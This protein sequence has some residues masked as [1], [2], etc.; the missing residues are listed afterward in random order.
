MTLLILKILLTLLSL[1]ALI[2]LFVFFFIPYSTRRRMLD[3]SYGTNTTATAKSDLLLLAI[4]LIL[5]GLLF[6]SGDTEYISFATGLYV[7]MTLIQIY[8]HHFSTPLPPEKSPEP[9]I[10]PIKLMSYA[11]QANPEKPWKELLVIG[12]LFFGIL[13]M[14]L[15]RGFNLF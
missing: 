6:F 5:L 15:T 10:S 4:C 2:K 14:L 8:F 7:G 1:Q 13:Y 12:I 9:P 11:I 3:K